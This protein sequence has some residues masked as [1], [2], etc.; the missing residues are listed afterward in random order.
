MREHMLQNVVVGSC[1]D[2]LRHVMTRHDTTGV[3]PTACWSGSGRVRCCIATAEQTALP[4]AHLPVPGP[5]HPVHL[6]SPPCLCLSHRVSITECS[7]GRSVACWASPQRCGWCHARKWDAAFAAASGDTHADSRQ[8]QVPAGSTT[9]ASGSLWR[10]ACPRCRH[11]WRPESTQEWL[12]HLDAE[13]GEELGRVQA[14]GWGR[15]HGGGPA[16]GQRCRAA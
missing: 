10:P 1:H 14:R 4:S 2:I 6:S 5:G 9:H 8:R 3:V 7:Q 16:Q 15:V 12:L 11:N 13:T